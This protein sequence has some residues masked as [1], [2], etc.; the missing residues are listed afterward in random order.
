MADSS[1]AR[2]E[3]R[4][5]RS[6]SGETYLS[7]HYAPYPFHIARVL[8]PDPGW[9]DLPTLCLQSAAGGLFQGDRLAVAVD[10]REG[11]AA[12][13]TSQS[14]TKAHGMPSRQATQTVALHLDSDSYLEYLADPVILFPESRVSSSLRIRIARGA[15][16]IARES[17][18]HHDPAGSC[19]PAFDLFVSAVSV[20]DSAGAL[21]ALDRQRIERPGDHD[22]IREALRRHRAQGSIYIVGAEATPELLTALRNVIPQNDELYGGVSSLPHDCGAYARVLARDGQTLRSV[23]DLAGAVARRIITGRL[24]KATW[25]K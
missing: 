19:D 8:H 4:F 21:L 3:F 12:Q 13:I 15:R 23:L 25:R 22:E 2:A 14:A 17:F 1:D 6:P 16:A 10:M 9:P 24:T 11:T 5:R 20:V 18:L 7:S